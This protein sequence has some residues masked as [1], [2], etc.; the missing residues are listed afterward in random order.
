MDIILELKVTINQVKT[1]KLCLWYF[2]RFVT[3]ALTL[4]P[5]NTNIYVFRAVFGFCNIYVTSC[6]VYKLGVSFLH[7]TL[8]SEKKSQLFGVYIDQFAAAQQISTAKLLEFLRRFQTQEPVLRVKTLKL[9]RILVIFW[10][11]SATFWDMPCFINQSLGFLF[12]AQADFTCW[13]DS[14]LNFS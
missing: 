13:K 4:R 5:R 6:W 1:K 7:S 12:Q 10:G 8:N 9:F 3:R 11:L 2:Y 14:P